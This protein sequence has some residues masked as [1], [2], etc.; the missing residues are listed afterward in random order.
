LRRR[1]F[2]HAS[3]V[4][5]FGV[6]VWEI[7]SYGEEPWCGYRGPEILQ[8]ITNGETLA[9]PT[10]CPKELYELMLQCWS[11]T[12]EQRP[13][14]L[15]LKDL[16]KEL[17]FSVGECREVLKGEGLLESE[18][19]DKIIIVDGSPE[20][21]YWFG[22]N[23]RTRK[24]GN[25]SRK[26]IFFRS[27][28]SLRNPRDISRP[29]KGSFIHAGH[30]DARGGDSWGQADKIDPIYLRNPMPLQMME[31]LE[32]ATIRGAEVVESIMGIRSNRQSVPTP[33]QPPPPNSRSSRSGELR[34]RTVI[35]T[36]TP[37]VSFA[38]TSSSSSSNQFHSSYGGGG[39]TN[40]SSEASDEIDPFAP[41]DDYDDVGFEVNGAVASSSSLP[42]H[43]AVA[44]A[45]AMKSSSPH[46][47]YDPP[48]VPAES[49]SMTSSMMS[50]QHPPLPIS[51]AATLT[52]GGH[53]SSTVVQR[54]QKSEPAFIP[55]ARSFPSASSLPSHPEDP[56]PQRANFE[57]AQSPEVHQRPI[58]IPQPPPPTAPQVLSGTHDSSMTVTQPVWSLP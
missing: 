15:A 43:P 29:I 22:Q 54:H 36:T 3:D 17:Q 23:V 30:G 46:S 57:F 33:L 12:P 37:T 50:S 11:I 34:R 58:V 31:P 48:P 9:K 45:A 26:A 7:F 1:Q 51:P 8:R 38:P 52:N 56:V 55:S 47:Y 41:F 14:F 44:A 42:S 39:G 40:G 6:T 32:P 4:W 21:F 5:S 16:I 25:F 10:C 19:N 2:S 53:S 27:R 24:Y 18:V 28:S 20:S 35:G 49:P 13:R